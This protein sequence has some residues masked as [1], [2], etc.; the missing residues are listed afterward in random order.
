MCGICGFTG[1]GGSAASRDLLGRM[2]GLMRHRGPDD[3]GQ[4]LNDGWALGMRR[5]SIIDVGGG[6]QP[7][8]SEDGSVVMVANGELYNFRSLRSQLADRGH[9]FSTGTDVEVAVHAYEEWGDDFPTRING[10]F[11]IAIWDR[12][13]ERLLLTRDR[14]GIKPLYHAA[15]RTGL[16]FASELAPLMAHPDVG[17]ELDPGALDAY[18]EMEFVPTPLSI[19]AGVRRLEPGHVLTWSARTGAQTRRYWDIDL[20]AGANAPDGDVAVRARELMDV[21]R[22]AVEAEMVSDV[23]LGVFLSGGLDS[24]TVA[25]AMCDVA[26]GAVHSF[27][28]GFRDAEFDESAVARRV[29]EHLGTVHRELIL[30]PD[31]VLAVIPEVLGRMDEPLADSSLLP[32][33]VLSRFARDHVTVALGGDGGDELFAGYP[34]MQAHRLHRAYRRLPRFLAEGVVPAIVNRLPVSSGYMSLDFRARRFVDGARHP[35]GAR[36]MRWMGSF[37]PEQRDRLYSAAGLAR[38]EDWTAP[39]D[40]HLAAV[41]SLDELLQVMYLDLKLY[42]EGDILT[43]VDRASMMNSLEVRVPLLNQAVVEHVASLPMSLKLRGL[44]TKFLLRAAMA[45]RLP[46][47]VLARRKQ[48][49]ALPMARWMRGPLRGLVESSLASDRVA[50]MGLLRPEAVQSLLQDHMSGRRD[51]RK[52]LW[53]LLVLQH[54]WDARIRPGATAARA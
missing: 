39:I 22:G 35:V 29:A 51:N 40:T 8:T 1:A 16:V 18:L 19:V 5:L 33:F 3:E 44:R 41:A 13:R 45:D 47:E 49:F 4:A 23:P 28:I 30:E 14:M 31:D 21:I 15:T 42:M 24:S 10:M 7:I 20:A 2:C 32:T 34:T 26:P 11:A 25:A 12:R 37:T 46:R 52:P 48:G 27:A 17:A 36:H 9:V 6:H 38:R 43:K 54:W 50:A 53:T